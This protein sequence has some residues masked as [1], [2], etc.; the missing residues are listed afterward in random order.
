MEMRSA[1]LHLRRVRLRDRQVGCAPALKLA[2]Q[3]QAADLLDTCERRNVLD[4]VYHAGR[5][6][7]DF[8]Q[9]TVPDVMTVPDFFYE[10]TCASTATA[11]CMMSR[12]SGRAMR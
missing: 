6:L 11:A 4:Q 12:S 2:A 8:A 9:Y 5:R 3:A 10:P 1:D 7:P